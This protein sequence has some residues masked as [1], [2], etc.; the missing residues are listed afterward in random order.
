M[1]VLS[2]GVETCHLASI[3]S[4]AAIKSLSKVMLYLRQILAVRHLPS[5]A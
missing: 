4:D 1:L 3:F 5:W 2:A